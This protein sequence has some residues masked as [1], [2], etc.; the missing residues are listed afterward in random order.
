M[1]TRVYSMAKLHIETVGKCEKLLTCCPLPKEERTY[2]EITGDQVAWAAWHLQ[3]SLACINYSS[4]WATLKHTVHKKSLSTSFRT[5]T[6]ST[7]P[8]AEAG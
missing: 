8:S 1:L 4:P 2:R 7:E 6:S 5:R 3:N